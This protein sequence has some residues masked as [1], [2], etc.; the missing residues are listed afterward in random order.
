MMIIILMATC[1]YS[2]SMSVIDFF[3]S[4]LWFLFF[5]FLSFCFFLHH[6]YLI[7]WFDYFK[8]KKIRIHDEKSWLNHHQ[9]RYSIQ[10]FFFLPL[11]KCK[12]L[13]LFT[14]N[15]H[16]STAC[17]I[18]ISLFSWYVMWNIF[19]MFSKAIGRHIFTSI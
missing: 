12:R 5:S 11:Q 6:S 19:F 3:A 18:S 14:R 1:W 4:S 16:I 9:K 8:S 7:Y 2:S 15:H 13:L 17:H 10:V